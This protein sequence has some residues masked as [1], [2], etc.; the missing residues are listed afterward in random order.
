[1]RLIT[2]QMLHLRVNLSADCPDIQ[3]KKGIFLKNQA[4][5]SVQEWSKKAH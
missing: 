1:V 5:Y 2:G 4:H 3:S